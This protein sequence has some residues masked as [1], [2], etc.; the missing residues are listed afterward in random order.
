MTD[1]S[2]KRL[3]LAGRNPAIPVEDFPRQWRRHAKVAA[4]FPS[5]GV[6]Y[7]RVQ[8]CTKIDDTSSIPGSSNGHAGVALLTMS[9]LLVSKPS[10]DSQEIREHLRPDEVRVFGDVVSKWS[11]Y[12]EEVVL[13]DGPPENVCVM[14]FLKRKEGLSRA[15]FDRHCA[16][17]HADLVL[18]QGRVVPSLRRYVQDRGLV[19]PPP[20]YEF[21]C[22]SELWFDDIEGAARFMNDA[23][24]RQ[25]VEADLERFC[26]TRTLV[27]MVTR[28]TYSWSPAAA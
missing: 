16:G 14:L 21:D 12:T 3:Y 5:V 1:M 2:F 17:T 18:A 4:G 20:G 25:G 8:H 24:Y 27:T 28:V 23:G 10:E 13:K 26:D 7:L 15:D 9:E 22:V 11:L 19:E 6:R